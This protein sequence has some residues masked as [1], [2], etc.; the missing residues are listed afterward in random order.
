MSGDAQDDQPQADGGHALLYVQQR[1]P[2]D[3]QIV[4]GGVETE[5]FQH[6]C[7]CPCAGEPVGGQGAGQEAAVEAFQEAGEVR[8]PCLDIVGVLARAPGGVGVGG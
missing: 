8:Q 6:A 4:Y 7:G 3:R 1:T 5:S 2:G